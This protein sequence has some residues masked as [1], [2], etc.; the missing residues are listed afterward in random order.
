M[1]CPLN[2]T[3]HGFQ[4]GQSCVTQLL[5]HSNLITIAIEEKFCVDVVYLDFSKA[6]D[7]VSH[8]YLIY[9]MQQKRIPEQLVN[10]T[11]AFLTSRRQRVVL[12]GEFSEW[13][14]VT[15]GVPQGSVL[16]PLLF[17]IY[18]DDLDE[19]IAPN[20]VIGKFADDTKLAQIFN[21]ENKEQEMEKL[22]M[23]IDNVS[24]WC[25]AWELPINISK[26][27]VLHYGKRN[28]ANTYYINGKAIPHTNE[29]RDLGVIQYNNS[30][31]KAHIQN[32]SKK[33][34]KITGLL[35]RTFQS[36]N[37]KVLLPIYKTLIR[38]LVEYGTPI[39]NPYNKRDVKE[40]EH[41]QRFFTKRISGLSRLDYNSRLI[42]LDL[43]TL[44]IR[45]KYFDILMCHKL[46]HKLVHSKCSEHLKVKRSATRGHQFKLVGQMS[47]ATATRRWFFTERIVNTWN[48]LPAEIANITDH[49]RF[50]SAVRKLLK[51]N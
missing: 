43:P 37:P 20:T 10:W 29:I 38:P 13:L 12:Q 31:Y 8:T 11:R 3:Q 23:S 50:K 39:W 28:I 25:T 47:V 7:K 48:Q 36:R 24:K 27:A 6:F 26:C 49:A 33:A 22:Q 17:S 35:L 16:G 44:E 2:K 14:P 42:R 41:V 5:E 19:V 40:I 30:K 1:E 34:R 15:S 32:M 4:K 18:I 51:I 45:R 9:K 21:D 46:L